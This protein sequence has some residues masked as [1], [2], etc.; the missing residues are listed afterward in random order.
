MQDLMK[1]GW[2]VILLHDIPQLD[3]TSL[4]N[5]IF[6]TME[7]KKVKVFPQKYLPKHYDFIIYFD[8]KFDLLFS[9]ILTQIVSWEPTTAAMLHVRFPC[10]Y[11]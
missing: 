9:P 3:T 8:N 6:N 5:Q 11:D 4:E 1:M 7:S 2:R 10:S